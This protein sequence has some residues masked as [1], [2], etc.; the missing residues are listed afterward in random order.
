MGR[1]GRAV[2]QR[3]GAGDARRGAAFGPE[4]LTFARILITAVIAVERVPAAHGAVVA[5]DSAPPSRSP[6]SRCSPP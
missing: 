6:R 1:G 4:T 3:H 2:L 5:N